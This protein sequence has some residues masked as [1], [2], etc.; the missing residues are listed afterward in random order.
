MPE[1]R[2][3]NFQNS[4]A[5][6]RYNRNFQGGG[7]YGGKISIHLAYSKDNLFL[8]KTLSLNTIEVVHSECISVT[9]DKLVHLSHHKTGNTPS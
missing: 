4:K 1:A 6:R 8:F 9:P 5:S 7:N 2:R 3:V